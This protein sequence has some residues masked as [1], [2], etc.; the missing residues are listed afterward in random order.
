MP[1]ATSISDATPAL[2]IDQLQATLFILMT[3]YSFD[4][5]PL[6]A[7]AIVDHL[8]KLLQHPCINLLPAQYA[9]LAKLLNK[10]RIHRIDKP[11]A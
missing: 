5:S 2:P 1:V 9:A 7:A 11:A 4:K 10:W 6:I 3:Q 8:H